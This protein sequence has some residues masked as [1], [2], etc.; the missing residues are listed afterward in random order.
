MSMKLIKQN[1]TY[2]SIIIII[3]ILF[4]LVI[5]FAVS[6]KYELEVE[7]F[8]KTI[9]AELLSAKEII[10]SYFF[11][12]KED[13]F[14]IKEL[15]SIEGYVDSDFESVD[16]DKIE[17][18]FYAFMQ[19]EFA[20][21]QLHYYQIT[22]LDTSG[23]E[24]VRVDNKGDGRTEV[25]LNS[26]LQNKKDRCYFQEAMKLE[27]DQ[28]YVSPIG[29]NIEWEE[30][31][32]PHKPVI[33]LATPLFDS[34][35]E[36]K[37][38]LVLSM[39][40]S[41]IFKYLPENTFIQTEEGNLIALNL[42]GVDFSEYG[43]VNFTKS[44]YV[45]NDDSGLLYISDVEFIRYSTVEFFPDKRLVVAIYQD[46]SL[47]SE[48]LQRLKLN[49][50]M[51][52][53]AFLGLILIV[54][55]IGILRFRE[56]IK[57]QKAIIFS[58]AKLT[59]SRDPETGYHL[60][61]TR[62]YSVALA[63][64]LRNNKKYRKIITQEFIDDLYEVAPLHDIGKVGIPD[65]ILLK[66]SRLTDE[67]YEK[68]KKHVFIGEQVL[69]DIIDRF[70]PKQSFFIMARNICAYHHE[71]YNGQGY[72]KGLKREEI[73]LEARIFA[74]ADA[75]DAIRSKRPYKE[76]LP[77]VEAVRIIKSDSGKHFDPDIVEA[78]LKC[79]QEFKEIS[80]TYKY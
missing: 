29:L 50:L 16:K 32:A 58:L 37:G 5:N 4:L 9:S 77:H 1:K 38:I 6:R 48:S 31:E 8:N 18:I 74:L 27:K 66:D 62:S 22:I 43:S 11:D 47:L 2:I 57:A 65:S 64:E 44:E 63:R 42:D 30:I 36:K 51:F 75:Y 71:K 13:L 56:M 21:G 12:F 28:V 46:I 73:P 15:L 55:S 23:Y 33:K 59:E 41:G 24:V 14:F 69:Q 20:K 79:E 7:L 40:L 45:F 61:R 3:T 49:Y 78:F 17:K 39:C 35:N 68:M 10:E 52:C 34:K 25:A 54:S 26:E 67:E 72:L 60:E 70:Q 19:D 80:D 76:A 53:A